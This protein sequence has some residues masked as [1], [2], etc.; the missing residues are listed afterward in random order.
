M[1]TLVRPVRALVR[2]SD[3]LLAA[4][5]NAA[6]VA[7][8]GIEVVTVSNNPSLPAPDVVICDYEGGVELAQGQKFRHA[9]ARHAP[10]VIVI[11]W[12]DSE[13]DV[14]TA[15]QSGV[16]GYL[17][18]NCQLNELVDALPQRGCCSARGEELHTHANDDARERDLAIDGTRHAEQNDRVRIEH[19]FGH[20]QVARQ[21]DTRQAGRA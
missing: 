4:G 16:A 9:A 14:R 1:T 2:H 10:G 19:C 12:R 8:L 5:I 3:P 18:G 21:V 6:L 17:F 7:A 11:T 13:A 15:L 20:G